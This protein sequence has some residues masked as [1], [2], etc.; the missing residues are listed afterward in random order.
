MLKCQKLLN[1]IRRAR[2]ERPISGCRRQQEQPS[3]LEHTPDFI[4]S[5]IHDVCYS[6]SE[7]VVDKRGLARDSS[8]FV[9]PLLL[10]ILVSLLAK[11]AELHYV[12]QAVE[13]HLVLS[14]P[15]NVR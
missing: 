9:Q 2:R 8:D 11:R 12:Y 7:K 13:V 1:A 6:Y 4:N 3:A 10:R 14:R 5:S 15:W